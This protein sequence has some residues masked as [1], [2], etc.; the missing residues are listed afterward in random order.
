MSGKGPLL[1]AYLRGE[2]N[3]EARRRLS[4]A[5]IDDT[6]LRLEFRQYKELHDLLELLPTLDPGPDFA[7][8]I[9]SAAHGIR[10]A[11]TQ[12][13]LVLEE[14]QEM[15][16]QERAIPATPRFSR[17][18]FW[19]VLA[20]FMLV[21]GIT[22]VFWPFSAVK[23]GAPPA[24]HPVEQM[25]SEMGSRVDFPEMPIPFQR[26]PVLLEEEQKILW[27]EYFTDFPI[28]KEGE[29]WPP[30]PEELIFPLPGSAL[31]APVLPEAF[32]VLPD[33]WPVNPE[34]PGEDVGDYQP[35]EG[36]FRVPQPLPHWSRPF[37]GVD[38]AL[39]GESA[40]DVA[41]GSLLVALEGLR[42]Q[43]GLPREDLDRVL[44]FLEVTPVEEGIGDNLY[45]H[46]VY[47]FYLAELVKS[48]QNNFGVHLDHACRYL[49]KN[50]NAD[51]GWGF[52]GKPRPAISNALV[53]GW[54]TLALAEA[55]KEGQ[56]KLDRPIEKARI[57]FHRL[58]DPR[59][60]ECGFFSRGDGREPHLCSLFATLVQLT[61]RE[62][63]NFPRTIE[64]TRLWVQ[65][66]MSLQRLEREKWID[67]DFLLIARRFTVV[68]EGDW[69]HELGTLADDAALEGRPSR[70]GN[71]SLLTRRLF[72]GRVK[73][74]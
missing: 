5:L 42:P 73:N 36:E 39:R 34:M 16:V 51:G 27:Q 33:P 32:P 47:T 2:L 58:T 13:D 1:V 44:G 19:N 11:E 65:A 70:W 54:A 18:V 71:W 30:K 9:M 60:A 40:A 57:F 68:T 59:Q 20:V 17:T 46:A 64:R 53:S 29:E 8:D 49:V 74:E 69:R 35:Q 15:E 48:G 31:E 7:T 28:A 22:L 26:P 38:G 50:Q 72:A 41:L 6:E 62:P 63:K 23:Q 24:L 67:Y 55:R 25:F 12:A 14:L 37:L 45:Q 10:F 4:D 56:D 66:G 43:S 52:Y 3:A 21:T 61:R